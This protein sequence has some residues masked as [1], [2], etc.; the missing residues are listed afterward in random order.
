MFWSKL[1]LVFLSKLKHVCTVHTRRKHLAFATLSTCEQRFIHESSFRHLHRATNGGAELPSTPLPPSLFLLRSTPLKAL[2]CVP[3]PARTGTNR[4]YHPKL[5]NFYTCFQVHFLFDHWREG[6]STT[7]KIFPLACTRLKRKKTI[8]RNLIHLN[9][10]RPNYSTFSSLNSKTDPHQRASSKIIGGWAFSFNFTVLGN[11]YKVYM[12]NLHL[13]V[14]SQKQTTKE[15]GSIAKGSPIV[16]INYNI[17][18]H[19]FK[20]AWMTFQL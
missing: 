19:T 11:L 17:I 5:T 14:M 6:I 7:P 16:R 2:V 3:V 12:K 9:K 4:P 20:N 8:L 15:I 18:H 13:R 1:G 10:E